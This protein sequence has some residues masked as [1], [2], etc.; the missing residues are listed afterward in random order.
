V[1]LTEVFTFFELLG[2][3]IKNQIPMARV[4]TYL[5]FFGAQ[6]DLRFD[7]GERHGGGAGSPSHH[8]QAQRGDRLQELRREHAPAGGACA[9]DQPSVSALL[10]AFD[11][12]YVPEANR[13][14]DRDSG[15]DQG[16]AGA[17]LPAAGSQVDRGQAIPNLLLPVFRPVGH[18]GRGQRLRTRSG[19]VPSRRHITAERAYWSGSLKAWVF[20]N[21]WR[22]RP[23]QAGVKPYETFQATT[24]PELDEPP[25]YSEGSQARQADDFHELARLHREL[26]QSGFDTTQLRIQY[27]KEVLRAAV[28]LHPGYDSIPFALRGLGTAGRWRAWE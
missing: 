5:F 27:Y 20:E 14:Q 26:Q 21:G 7:A 6:A 2:D 13:R 1:L 4:F 28:C 18:D 12:Y 10:F 8:D 3:I 15:R 22:R 24:F 19:V 25:S 17:D 23:G 16:P 11:Y 9:A